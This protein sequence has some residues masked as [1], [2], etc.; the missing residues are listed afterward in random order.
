MS[1]DNLHSQFVR[2]E[3]AARRFALQAQHAKQLAARF[4][5]DDKLTLCAGK[6][7]KRN[8]VAEAAGVAGARH[9]LANPS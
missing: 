2:G 9:L 7:G 8:L 5:R 4:E 1:R 3:E 6:A